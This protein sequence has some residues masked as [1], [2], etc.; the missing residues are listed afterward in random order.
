VIHADTFHVFSLRDCPRDC[1]KL[2]A[3]CSLEMVDAIGPKGI[4]HYS[5][6]CQFEFS[7][8]E[9]RMVDRIS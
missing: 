2:A 1:C 4:V 9:L 8:S 6:A 3:V 7:F 5:N